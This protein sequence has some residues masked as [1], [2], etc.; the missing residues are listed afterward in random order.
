MTNH[1]FKIGDKVSPKTDT[2]LTA[3]V[4]G[5]VSAIF[6]NFIVADFSGDSVPLMYNDIRLVNG[7]DY[8]FQ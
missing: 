1:H 7:K 4:Q 5:T 3:G 6:P 8:L 2:F